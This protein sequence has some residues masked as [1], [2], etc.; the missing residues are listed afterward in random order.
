M[1]TVSRKTR[2]IKSSK[3]APVTLV[4]P[5]SVVSTYSITCWEPTAQ[6]QEP[7]RTFHNG[8][9]FYTW[10]GSPYS[11]FTIEL[12]LAQPL[13]S[14]CNCYSVP[15][16]RHLQIVPNSMVDSQIVQGLFC[17]SGKFLCPCCWCT[18]SSSLNTS[19][20]GSVWLHLSLL[21]N[22]VG[23][24]HLSPHVSNFPGAA[25]KMHDQSNLRKE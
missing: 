13:S 8:P 1:E 14:W 22:Q 10:C 12:L 21:G 24:L 11:D 6:A 19:I 20:P 7:V 18:T 2:Q 5:I 4:Y 9:Y 23:L 17:S 3:P 15:Q 16:E 25:T